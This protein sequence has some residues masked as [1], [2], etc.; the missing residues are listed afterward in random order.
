MEDAIQLAASLLAFPAS[1]RRAPL[2]L[3]AAEC[4][5]LSPRCTRVYLSP[6]ARG[7]PTDPQQPQRVHN[8]HTLLH[9]CIV[10]GAQVAIDVRARIETT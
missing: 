6:S 9:L 5:E 3:S 1:S 8:P 4:V 2:S 10:G 7:N